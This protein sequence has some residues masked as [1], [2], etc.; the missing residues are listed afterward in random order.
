M[1]FMLNIITTSTLR[2]HINLNAAGFETALLK[3]RAN[4]L[5]T[6]LCVLHHTASKFLHGLYSIFIS[7]LAYLLLF[8]FYNFRYAIFMFIKN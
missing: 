7:L 3:N 2:K 8:I 4:A 6:K 1:V 5:I